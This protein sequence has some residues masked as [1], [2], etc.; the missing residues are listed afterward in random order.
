MSA[1]KNKTTSLKTARRIS[2]GILY[3]SVS[4]T[5]VVFGAF[6]LFGTDSLYGVMLSPVASFLTD[7]V[8]ITIYIF[9]AATM[10]LAAWSMTRSMRR[11]SEIIDKDNLI[12]SAKIK[13]GIF[14]FVALCLIAT[15]SLASN[16]PVNI[17]GEAF[18]NRIMLRITDMFINTT[19][20]L[21]VTALGG[22]FYGMSGHIR[23]RK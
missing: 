19:L 23:K 15:F 2:S 1:K 7:A 8:I 17:N 18:D 10:A 13:R 9:I 22:L 14:A 4:L 12:N 21:I 20:I 5:A 3:A 6:F 16:E 11:G